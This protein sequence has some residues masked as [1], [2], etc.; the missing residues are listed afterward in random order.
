MSANNPPNG[1]DP[2]R[3]MMYRPQG[4]PESDPTAQYPGQPYPPQQPYQQP[5]GQPHGQGAYDQQASQPQ[6]GQPQYGQP[7]YGQQPGQPQYGQQQYGQPQYQQPQ[8]QQPQYGQQ[9]GQQQWQPQQP[10]QGWQQ[11]QASWPQQ[12]QPQYG[13]QGWQ[14]QGPEGFGPPQPAKKGGKGWLIAIA[15]TLAVVLFGG[16]AVWAVG[17]LGGGGAQPSDV[18]PAD[19]LAYVRLDLDPAANQKVALF[20]LAGKF[21]TT[22]DKFTGEDP[23]E[24][25]FKLFDQD[26]E[27][28]ADFAKDIDPWLGSRIGVAVVPSGKEDPDVA[29]AVQVTDEEAAKAGIA[30]L[31]DGDKYGIAFR[32]DYALVAETQ[33]LATKY[34]TATGSLSDNAEFG[35]DMNA[36][37][38][39]GILSFWADMNGVLQAAKAEIPA[40]QAAAFEQLKN[41]RFAGA[42]RFDSAFVELAGLTRGASGMAADGDLQPADL[43]T[44]PATTAGALSISGLDEVLTKNWGEVQK[45]AGA[46][47]GPE[48]QQFL[49]QIQTQLGLKLPDDLATVVGKNLTVAVDSEG[50]E[51]NQIKGGLRIA[52][53]PAKA[54]A[55][56]DKVQRGLTQGGAALPPIAKAA[57]DGVFTVA[58]T[59]EYAKALAAQ[60]T[61]GESEAFRTAIPNAGEANFA[62]FVDLDKIEKLYLPSMQ[63]DDK[64]NAEVLRAVGLSGTRS[65]SEASFSLRVLFN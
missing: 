20:Q 32:D 3:T 12:Q 35:D 15:A 61:L 59:E 4:G 53:D 10:Q 19:A 43:S 44:L 28:K 1:Q 52:T 34:A 14:Q 7:A 45:Q 62:I 63:G 9:P 23:R 27:S 5:Y 13:Q 42:L 31:M 65:D 21:S 30:K 26:T 38:E 48:A 29:V 33:E 6:P 41:A 40:E 64:A 25:L 50:L 57:G 17:A 58:T 11:E 16:G 8:Y 46:S 39:Q 54:Q 24:A 56:I 2:D 18:L 47:G 49:Q 22:K 60:G 51:S 37:G 36:L 55:I